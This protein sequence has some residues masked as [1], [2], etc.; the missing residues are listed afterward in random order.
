M[1]V[2]LAYFYT[3][4]KTNVTFKSLTLNL[5]DRRSLYTLRHFPILRKMATCLLVQQRE[6]PFESVVSINVT[7]LVHFLIF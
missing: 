5:Y 1:A 2:L 6:P 4:H 3:S 7:F